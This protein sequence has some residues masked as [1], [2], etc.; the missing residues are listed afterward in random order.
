MLKLNVFLY[1]LLST[2]T[3]SS[4]EEYAKLESYTNNTVNEVSGMLNDPKLTK[5]Q[6]TYKARQLLNKNLGLEW[7][8]K[9]TLGR[10]KKSLSK[11]QIS[12]FVKVYSKYIIDIYSDM[13][14]NYKGQKSIVK[15]T[16]KIDDKE[17][18]V[19]MEIDQ[20]DGKQPIKV[21]YLVIDGSTDEINDNFKIVDIVTEGVSLVNSQKDQFNSAISSNGFE[22]LLSE[23]K[24][25]ANQHQSSQ[26]LKK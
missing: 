16:K 13:V 22:F 14:K 10:N 19:K 5:E 15:G 11:E 7:M 17:F 20:P 21:D 24:R 6:K 12:Q 26:K 9:Y 25:M 18:I 8:A 4:T 2:F 3:A 23:L 1:I